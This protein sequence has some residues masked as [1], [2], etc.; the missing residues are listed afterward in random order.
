MKN[1]VAPMNS[2][3]FKYFPAEIF[4]FNFN[5]WCNIG[6]LLGHLGRVCSA[7]QLK[8]KIGKVTVTHTF[9]FQL[10]HGQA[11]TLHFILTVYH[12]LN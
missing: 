11:A 12:F 1:Q 2:F 5:T 9:Y 7:F 3:F 8:L 6:L 10:Y 4:E